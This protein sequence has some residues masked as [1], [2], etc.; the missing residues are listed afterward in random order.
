MKTPPAGVSTTAWLMLHVPRINDACPGRV[1][2]APSALAITSKKPATTGVPAA[3]PVSRRLGG[4]PSDDL[5]RPEQLRQQSCWTPPDHRVRAAHRHRCWPAT[6][7][8]P[9]RPCRRCRGDLAGQR[10]VT[11]SL[12]QEMRRAPSPRAGAAPPR[13]KRRRLR[14]PRVLAGRCACEPHRRRRRRAQLLG[15]A[16]GARVERLDSAQWR[17]SRVEQ[18]EPVAMAGASDARRRRTVDAALPRAFADQP[19]ER[20]SAQLVEVALDM[21]GPGH[22]EAP[23]RWPTPAARPSGRTARP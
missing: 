16:G 7:T 12:H 23:L 15:G 11:R 22:G 4:H 10:K 13:Q 6:A 8:A 2:P 5:D 19:V 18:V 9:H 20:R 17:A 3:S 1:T 21:A 14:R